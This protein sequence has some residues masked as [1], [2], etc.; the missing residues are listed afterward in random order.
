MLVALMA[1]DKPKSLDI[2]KANRAAHLD[3]IEATGVVSMA[4]PFLDENGSMTGSL[5]ILDV[6]DMDA[7]RSWAEND[8]YA[9]AGLF[10]T[11]VLS[12]WKKVVG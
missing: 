11:V 4:G 7:A 6:A 9:K 1:R 12:E 10:E 5:V 3:Y 2:R 8:P